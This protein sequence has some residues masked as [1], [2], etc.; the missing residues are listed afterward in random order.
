MM[1]MMMVIEDDG[2]RASEGR[3]IR[4]EC[5]KCRCMRRR[6][7]LVMDSGV[8]PEKIMLRQRRRSSMGRPRSYR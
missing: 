8:G 7:N 4:G 5:R 3:I 1:M 2:E 6:K